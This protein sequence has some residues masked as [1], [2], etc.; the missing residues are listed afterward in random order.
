MKLKSIV[1]PAALAAFLLGGCAAQ[2]QGSTSGEGERL[3]VL[4]TTYPTYL[5]ASAM[6]EGVEGVTVSRL[7]TGAVSCL[8]DY[9]LTV[10]DM[11]QI[12]Q[13]DVI[14][15][16]GAGLEDFMA[17]ALGSARGLVVDC[18]QG[19]ELLE[20]ED[21][22]HVDGDEADHGHWDPHYWM[23]PDLALQMAENIQNALVEADGEYAWNYQSNYTETAT[24]MAGWKDKLRDYCHYEEGPEISG[25]ITF[26]DGFRYFARALDLPLL[27][28][29]EEEEG[30]E[31][32]AME[33]NRITQLVEEN[34]LPVIFT[35]VNGSD[36][37][38]QAISR[39][40]GCAVAQL[41][42]LMDGPEYTGLQDYYDGLYGNVQA[43]VNGFAGEE[44]M[45]RS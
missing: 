45:Q 4:A 38:A 13:A 21:H 25:L 17:D 20:N 2:P 40:T 9:T 39:E 34:S 12:E 35:E 11:K 19:L 36:A 27:A 41:T 28:A 44:V 30:S 32:S 22:D 3:T 7:N 1:I 15:V 16:N 18:S 42:M 43:I 33:I 29:I 8:H 5:M 10:N 23:D 14:V 31:A 6:A 37:T 24:L 26:H